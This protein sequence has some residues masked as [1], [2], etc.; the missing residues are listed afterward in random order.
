MWRYPTSRASETMRSVSSGATLNTPKPSWGMVEPSLSVML[1]TVMDPPYGGAATRGAYAVGLGTTRWS[2]PLYA[3][4]GRISEFDASCS[5]M[6][7]VHPV[8]RD[9]TNNGV[10][11]V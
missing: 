8:M 6:C 7:A 11:I 4:K 3:L 1:G 5:R 9:A 2:T 10:N